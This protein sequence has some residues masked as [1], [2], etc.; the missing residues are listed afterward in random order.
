MKNKY[1]PINTKFRVAAFA[2]LVL[3]IGMCCIGYQVRIQSVG[4]QS[5]RILDATRQSSAKTSNEESDT[6]SVIQLAYDRLSDQSR[7]ELTE[8]DI[9]VLRRALGQIEY[10][11]EWPG[12]AQFLA[13]E[14]SMSK[15]SFDAVVQYV[16]RWDEVSEWNR[17]YLL[18]VVVQKIVTIPTLGVFEVPESQSLLRSILNSPVPEGW[19]TEWKLKSISYEDS[20]IAAR[21]RGMAAVGLA[22][23]GGANAADELQKALDANKRKL[24]VGAQLEGRADVSGS[25]SV[26][27]EEVV[28][29]H[30]QEAVAICAYIKENSRK[31]YLYNCRAHPEII[32]RYIVKHCTNL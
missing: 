23:R 28:I 21:M 6:R 17:S 25:S 2:L 15:D 22:T 1:M 30:L 3:L 24:S 31:E 32:E 18:Q 9:I 20:E 7:R 4:V 14:D 5:H 16:T 27:P 13:T 11:S 26:A 19:L 29:Y 10:S 12:I 8:Q